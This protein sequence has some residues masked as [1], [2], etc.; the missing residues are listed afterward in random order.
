MEDE[1]GR[2][3][4]EEPKALGETE[5]VLKLQQRLA[6]LR[7]A[8]QELRARHWLRLSRKLLRTSD[9]R[10]LHAV[11]EERQQQLRQQTQ[12]LEYRLQ[13]QGL[14]GLERLQAQL[15][16]LQLG[17]SQWRLRLQETAQEISRQ[18]RRLSRAEQLCPAERE[19]L[20]LQAELERAKASAQAADA[21]RRELQQLRAEVRIDRIRTAEMKRPMRGVS[22]VALVAQRSRIGAEGARMSAGAAPGAVGAPGLTAV[23]LGTGSSFDDRAATWDTPSSMA[24][25][26]WVA[27]LIEAQPWFRPEAMGSCLDFGCGTGLLAFQLQG[28]CTSLVGVDTSEGMLQVMEAKI[29]GGGLETK[30]QAA[31]QLQGLP[32]FDLVV[33]LLCLHHVRDCQQQVQEL[34]RHLAPGGRMVLVDFEATKNARLFHKADHRLGEHYEHDGLVAEELLGWLRAADLEELELVRE[35]FQKDLAEGWP[36]AGNW[37]TFQMLLASGKAP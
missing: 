23:R 29:S 26:A 7:A 5:A 10:A 4:L 11:L 21:Q 35:P 32:T 15:E 30:M 12:L 24:R 16:D 34:A 13:A 8:A 2:R 33:S 9:K 18:G 27:G 3:V 22:W 36:G 25:V 14:E 1:R 6:K 37:E 31:R 20:R 28:H 19:L 17:G